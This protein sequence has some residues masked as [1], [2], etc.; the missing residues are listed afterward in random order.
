MPTCHLFGAG[1]NIRT[2]EGFRKVMDEFYRTVGLNF[3]K[4]VYLNDSKEPLGSKRDR[5]ESIGK[6]LLGQ[7]AFSFIMNSSIFNDIPMILETA[8][9]EK[10]KEEIE[11]LYSLIE[12]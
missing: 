11:L 3:L 5:H 2:K 6:G 10:Y 1:Y 12:K 8:D 7:E 4:G 9:P